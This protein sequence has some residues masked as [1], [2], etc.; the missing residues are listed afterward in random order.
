MNY[1]QVCI[2]HCKFV[3]FVAR[4]CYGELCRKRWNTTKQ[5]ICLMGAE[6]A[7]YYVR[8]NYTPSPGIMSVLA[9]IGHKTWLCFSAYHYTSILSHL[10][11][12]HRVFFC[13]DRH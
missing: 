3:A 13:C 4:V 5:F 12:L 9:I 2:A 6:T 10:F 11:M 1:G 8:A 7:L